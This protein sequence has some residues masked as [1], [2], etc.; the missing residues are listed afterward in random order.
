MKMT[1]MTEDDQADK[2]WP[3]ISQVSQVAAVWTVWSLFQLKKGRRR[4]SSQTEKEVGV[5]KLSILTIAIIFILLFQLLPLHKNA[6]E[7]HYTKKKKTKTFLCCVFLSFGRVKFSLVYSIENTMI[8]ISHNVRSQAE[9]FGWGGDGYSHP[10]T[11][12]S[13]VW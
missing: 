11:R 7:N 2:R 3:A 8:G 1:R 13:R 12:G 6:V 4:D 5:T 9:V 10:D